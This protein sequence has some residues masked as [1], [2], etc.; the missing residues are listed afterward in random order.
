MYLDETI[1]FKPDFERSIAFSFG[2]VPEN[3][4][5]LAPNDDASNMINNWID[6]ETNSTIKKIID[7]GINHFV[8]FLIVS[9]SS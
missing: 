5:F 6:R 3:V 2:T 8:F 9:L 1:L 7:R 4:N